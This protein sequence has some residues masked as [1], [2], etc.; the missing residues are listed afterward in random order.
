MLWPNKLWITILVAI[1][2]ISL[3]GPSQAAITIT[4]TEGGIPGSLV[5]TTPTNALTGSGS[6]GDYTFTLTTAV[7]NSPGV[8]NL[9]T[10]DV[11]STE[12][13]GIA[14][15]GS[16]GILSINVVADGFSIPDNTTPTFFVQTIG[17]NSSSSS[18]S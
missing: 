18:T 4:I 16:N 3:A 13:R 1:A 6:F 12:T 14:L 8:S 5:F 7:S 11:S 17:A 10:L 15:P 9:A 2:I